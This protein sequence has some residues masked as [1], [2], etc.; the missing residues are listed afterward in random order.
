MRVRVCAR[1]SQGWGNKR[2]KSRCLDRESHVKLSFLKDRGY[3]ALTGELQ[4]RRKR[5]QGSIHMN[6][7]NQVSLSIYPKE[8]KR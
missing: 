5:I 2:G 3:K 7:K 6:L 4:G 1:V 8:S